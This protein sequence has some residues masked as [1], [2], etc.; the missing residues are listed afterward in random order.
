MV[1]G[2]IIVEQRGENFVAKIQVEGGTL[3][4]VEFVTNTEKRAETL[5]VKYVNDVYADVEWV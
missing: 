2:Q 5:A 3:R 4:D 1:S